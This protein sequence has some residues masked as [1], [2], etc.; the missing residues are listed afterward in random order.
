[1]ALLRNLIL[2]HFYCPSEQPNSD[3]LK[4]EAAKQSLEVRKSH[5]LAATGFGDQH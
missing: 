2:N 4:Q 5:D 1:M 3:I